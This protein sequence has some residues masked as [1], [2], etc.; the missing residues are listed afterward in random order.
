[1]GRVTYQGFAGAWPGQTD[2]A[3]FADRM[4]ALPKHVVSTTLTSAD[5]SN[6]HLIASNVADEVAALKQGSGQDILINGSGDLIQ[7]LL[8][9]G[10]IDEYR[11]LV[12]HIVVGA[13]K[14]LFRDGAAAPLKVVETQTFPTGV[15]LLRYQPA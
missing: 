2:D 15:V 10:L 3:G 4:N 12:Y 9:L 7:S 11:L 5:W 1:L 13:G 14:R 6:S 8:P